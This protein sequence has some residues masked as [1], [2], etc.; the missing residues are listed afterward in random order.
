MLKSLTPS[1]QRRNASV[2]AIGLLAVALAGSVY[3]ASTP[4][5]GASGSA[6]AATEY[7]LNLKV[8]Q[9]T[10]DRHA[11]QAEGMVVELCM[12]PGKTGTVA[13][14]DRGWQIDATPSPDGNN[15]LRIDLAV[16]VAGK[17]V[18]KN[19]MEAKVGELA[20]A[21]DKGV[22]GVHDYAIEVTPLVGCPAGVAATASPVKV[23]EHLKNASVRAAAESVAAQAGWTLVNPDALGKGLTTLSF[24][25][26]PAG[27]ALL[28]LADLAG[29]QPVFE[30]KQVRFE[31]K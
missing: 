26:M 24:D 3:A 30:G 1:R 9:A 28:H 4:V 22:D 31:P 19:R 23:T 14:H 5:Q 6:K 11:R 15:R 20:H 2:V 12:A 21:N 29:V 10:G 27:S 7:Q 18:A 16:T 13:N 25:N 17:L 8:E